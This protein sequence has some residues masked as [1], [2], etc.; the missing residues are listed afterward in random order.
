M[1]T[2]PEL[3]GLADAM[4][5]MARTYYTNNERRDIIS[6]PNYEYLLDNF[7]T[8][9]RAKYKDTLMAHPS[10]GNPF[11]TQHWWQRNPLSDDEKAQYAFLR[12][13]LAY[14][15]D[16]WRQRAQERYDK[17]TRR[18][19][20]SFLG[21]LKF[22]FGASQPYKDIYDAKNPEHVK[23]KQNLDRENKIYEE[24]YNKYGEPSRDWGI[25][26]AYVKKWTP[27]E[28]QLFNDLGR[29]SII[30]P[31]PE[32]GGPIVAKHVAKMLKDKQRI[33]TQKKTFNN[34]PIYMPEGY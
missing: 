19:D 12:H 10:P 16:R 21:V 25:M 7:L 6:S 20:N 27:E 34:V 22:F 15:D 5:K 4:E 11:E 8:T 30:V 1:E 3:L 29:L 2:S 14:R 31:E 28:K 9:M 24:Q 26:N 18:P 13:G 23:A 17:L 33:P 32:R